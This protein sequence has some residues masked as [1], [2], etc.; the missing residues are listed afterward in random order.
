MVDNYFQKIIL[1]SDPYLFHITHISNLEGII[2][3]KGLLSRNRAKNF[4]DSSHLD[5]Q[6]KR[7]V[8]D[9]IPTGFSQS[10]HD[11]VPFYFAPLSPMLCAIHNHKVPNRVQEEMIYLVSKVSKVEQNNLPFIFSDGHPITKGLS[12]FF[13]DINSLT[14]ID[15][16][17]MKAKYWKDT[18]E[19]GDR[20]RRRQAEFLLVNSCPF[21]IISS[22]CVKDQTKLEY[23]E[24][25]FTKTA[26]NSYKP[27]IRI[28]NEWY[29]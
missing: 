7:L 18:E 26:P 5:V 1:P 8:I 9:K 21:E 14:E 10:L 17:L 11:Y 23:I 15:W 13:Q 6:E 12:D 24:E 16:E 22:I 25:I 3:N 19:D 29:Y 20:K 27:Q 2:Q 4:I 28:T